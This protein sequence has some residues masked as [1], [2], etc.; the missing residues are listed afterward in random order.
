MRRITKRV[1]LDQSA[2]VV[3]DVTAY[4]RL[5]DEIELLR[6]ALQAED[7]IASGEV[8]SNRAAKA[9]LRRRLGT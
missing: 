3:L 7:Q 8:L 1:N 2:A 5:L 4:E 9:E 6:D